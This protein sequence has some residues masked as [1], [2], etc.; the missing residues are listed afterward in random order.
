MTKLGIL[1]AVALV[2]GMSVGVHSAYAQ[3]SM[4][5]GPSTKGFLSCA[6]KCQKSFYF[7]EQS[8]PTFAGLRNACIEGRGS[9]VDAN[10]SAYQSC[11][12]GCQGI[13]PYRHGTNAEFAGFQK[14]CIAGC[15]RVR[16]A[17][18]ALSVIGNQT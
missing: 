12:I 9:V 11:N 17:G 7:N 10:I 15:R 5:R 16:S 14:T 1:L 13:F 2:L 18:L 3:A 6:K 4:P 8:D